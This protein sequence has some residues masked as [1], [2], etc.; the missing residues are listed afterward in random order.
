MKNEYG[1]PSYNAAFADLNADDNPFY[2]EKEPAQA[3]ERLRRTIGQ[4]GIAIA[5]ELRRLSQIQAAQITRNRVK[6]QVQGTG[7]VRSPYD[8]SRKREAE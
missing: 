1:K 6:L 7:T 8:A 3:M 4:V 5:F 2:F